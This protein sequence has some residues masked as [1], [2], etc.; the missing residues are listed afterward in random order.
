[1]IWNNRFCTFSLL[2]SLFYSVTHFC[3]KK[4]D[5]GARGHVGRPGP[6]GQRGLPGPPG[7]E[8]ER[9]IPG[10]PGDPGPKGIMVS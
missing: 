2:F 7:L 1:M 6:V 3:D 5:V 8:G 9:G 4:G 10:I